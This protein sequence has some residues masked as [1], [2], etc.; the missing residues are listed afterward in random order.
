MCTLDAI[1]VPAFGRRFVPTVCFP[2]EVVVHIVCTC[3]YLSCHSQGRL[4]W[5]LD[6]IGVRVTFSLELFAV[7][8][9]SNYLLFV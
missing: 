5:T 2:C 3:M 8:V 1:G 6:A 9:N 7:R 4:M